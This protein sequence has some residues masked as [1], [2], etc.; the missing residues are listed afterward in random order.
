MKI[1]KKTNYAVMWCWS[2]TMAILTAPYIMEIFKGVRDVLYVA[3][4]L[5]IGLIPLV[6]AW[7]LMISTKGKSKVIKYL[8]PIS[9]MVFYAV[10]LFENNYAVTCG[11]YFPMIAVIIMYYDLKYIGII[12][13]GML[14]CNV[15]GVVYHAM[16]TDYT[17]A[18]VTQWEIQ[19]AASLLLGVFLWYSCRI[20]VEINKG[21]IDEVEDALTQSEKYSQDIAQAT[22]KI[23][24][25]VSKVKDDL[26]S[27]TNNN[28][29]VNM[30]MHEVFGGVHSMSEELQKQTI[31]MQTSQERIDEVVNAASSI[32]ELSTATRNDFIVGNDEI[33]KAKDVSDR[34]SNSSKSTKEAMSVLVEKTKEAMGILEVIQGIS[35]Q[36][37]LL[38]LNASIEAARAGVLGKGFSVIADEIRDLSESTKEATE[39]ISDLLQELSGSEQHVGQDMTQTIEDVEI[40]VQT[41]DSAFEKFAGINENLKSL[42][43][44]IDKISASVE[45]LSSENSQVVDA[46]LQMSGVSEELSASVTEVDELSKRSSENFESILLEI[47]HISDTMSQMK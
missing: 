44:E 34:I 14:A 25:A 29:E 47:E 43:E 13:G 7:I 24:E 10:A 2:I 39:T 46:T 11:F 32:A 38:A 26:K 27:S 9:Y 42:D 12:A 19:I 18:M 33:T 20:L 40:Q 4:M 3:S 16:T 21:K 15:G 37:N 6:I 36:T 28:N 35:S 17:P 45:E 30:S 1:L 22:K 41:I 5:G 23:S 8:A 31:A